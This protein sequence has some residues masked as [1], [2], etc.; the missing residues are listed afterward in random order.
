MVWN[1]LT[2]SSAGGFLYRLGELIVGDELEMLT[3]CS[4]CSPV[5]VLR[6]GSC[7]CEGT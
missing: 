2:L 4:V 1:R 6:A 5:S 7:P 3:V